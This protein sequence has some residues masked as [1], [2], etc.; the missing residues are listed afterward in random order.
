M[1]LR[2]VTVLDVLLEAASILNDED[3]YTPQAVGDA[4]DVDGNPCGYTT[5]RAYAYTVHGACKLAGCRVGLGRSHADSDLFDDAMWRVAIYL[6][7][8]TGPF[9]GETVWV[10]DTQHASYAAVIEAFDEAIL[11]EAANESDDSL[12]RF[13]DWEAAYPVTLPDG[14]RG[15]LIIAQWDDDKLD[16]RTR[17]TVDAMYRSLADTSQH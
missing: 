7:G 10:A 12:D 14:E 5:S 8:R 2:P 15:E 6:P 11:K 13:L 3:H 16:C 4:R 17:T 9:A 1:P